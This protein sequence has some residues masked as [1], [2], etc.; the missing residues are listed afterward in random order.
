[1]ARDDRLQHLIITQTPTP[2]TSLQPPKRVSTTVTHTTTSQEW[3]REPT[4]LIVFVL[5]GLLILFGIIFY[6]FV[7]VGFINEN[8]NCNLEKCELEFENINVN[9]DCKYN[10]NW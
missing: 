5:F 1:M 6:V 8:E 4:T 9:V 10:F 3:Q 2:S 7:N